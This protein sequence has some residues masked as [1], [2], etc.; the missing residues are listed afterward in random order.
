M[1]ILRNA[2]RNIG[3]SKVRSILIAIIIT[4]IAFSVCIGLYIRQASADSRDAA[5]ANMKITAQITQNRSKAMKQ[6]SGSGTFSKSKLKKALG[7]ELTLT[8]LK[9]YAKASSVSSFYY[10]LTTSVDG[11]GNLEAY[12]S[13]SDS[14]S[15]DSSSGTPS[16]M[17]SM[18]NG[19]FTITGYSSDEAMT[20]FTSGT[21]KI[22]KGKMFTEGTS[23]MVCVISSELAKYNGL[24]V[25][26]T[27]KVSNP[28]KSSETYKLKIVGIYKDSQSSAQAVQGGP[29]ASDP[30][31]SI[32][33]S[34]STLN[35]IVTASKAKYSKNSTKALSS[36]LNGTYV[37]G[38]LSK[39]KSFKKE[40]KQLGLSS[41]YQVTSADLTNYEQ[42]AQPLKN[43]AKF[44]G[45]FLIVI[46]MVGAAILVVMNIFSTRERKYEIGVLTAIGM[47]KKQVAAFFLSEILILTLAGVI[48]GGAAGAAVSK[49]VTKK[50][51]S[52]QVA[53]SMKQS[54]DMQQSFGRDNNG[55]GPGSQDSGSGQN[56][57]GKGAPSG[58]PSAPSGS[59]ATASP[60]S[61]SS[62]ALNTSS[63]VSV[64]VL[65]ELLGAC[66]ALALIAGTVSVTA[67]MRYE[68]LDI[69]SERD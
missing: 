10:T 64:T 55:G 66:V 58:A 16:V 27:I 49:P 36:R 26:D 29:N 54:S 48:V 69:L 3:R 7:S 5:L 1:F 53:S 11:A 45:Y 47:K 23:D 38:T 40:V 39:Y 60:G 42:S 41:K 59:G 65:L 9:K 43:L 31:N 52:A 21:K 56:A 61:A 20:D 62:N 28:N 22:S 14:Q 24:S 12:S 8:Q 46:L 6:A 68:P 57:D 63:S 17:K 25:G 32:Y 67:I 15:S 19:E 18:D 30:A 13:S 44:A 4:I 35:R 37:V 50:L 2:M 34:Y 51:L 33:T